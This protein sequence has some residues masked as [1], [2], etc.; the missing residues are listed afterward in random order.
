MAHQRFRGVAAFAVA[1]FSFR[2]RKGCRRSKHCVADA[3]SA[4]PPMYGNRGRGGV[5]APTFQHVAI[6]HGTYEGQSA[7]AVHVRNLLPTTRGFDILHQSV[8]LRSQPPVKEGICG[9]VHVPYT[10]S[11]ETH[12][13]AL[14]LGSHVVFFVWRR[15]CGSAQIIY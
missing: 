7:S 13:D 2:V 5:G 10:S 4:W 6:T 9:Q 14:H 15:E 1:P 8:L 3:I 11:S 12:P